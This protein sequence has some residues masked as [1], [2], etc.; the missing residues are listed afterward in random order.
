[1]RFFRVHQKEQGANERLVQGVRF[2][3]VKV[4]MRRRF[5]RLYSSFMQVAIAGCMRP[6]KPAEEMV[7]ARFFL[8]PYCAWHPAV[9][10]MHQS[11]NEVIDYCS[12]LITKQVPEMALQ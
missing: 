8:S 3:A 9:G 10:S 7:C 5:P 12:V 4:W 1:V 2:C 6:E 11:R